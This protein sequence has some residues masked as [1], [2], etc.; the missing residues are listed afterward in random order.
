MPTT[1]CNK[2]TV[3]EIVSCA[4]KKIERETALFS[5]AAIQLCVAGALLHALSSNN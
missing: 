3:K 2:K 1:M 5:R 4:S